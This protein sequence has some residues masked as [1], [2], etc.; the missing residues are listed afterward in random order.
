GT[1][2]EHHHR[3]REGRRTGRAREG[4]GDGPP[5]AV[6]G[7]K[8]RGRRGRARSLRLLCPPRAD[9]GRRRPFRPL[10]A[11]CGRRAPRSGTRRVPLR[12]RTGRPGRVRDR[13]ALRPRSRGLGRAHQAHRRGRRAPALLVWHTQGVHPPGAAASGGGNRADEVARP[14]ARA[15]SAPEAGRV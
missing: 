6:D 11:G 5:G 2:T 9:D 7:G 10:P 14:N 15:S 3:R 8:G 13:P 4:P 1:V 12:Q